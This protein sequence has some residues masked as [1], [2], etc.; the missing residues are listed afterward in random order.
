[1][2]D[3]IRKSEHGKRRKDG[4]RITDE[5]IDL[6]I[7]WGREIH[8]K[9][10]VFYFVGRKEIEKA[11]VEGADIKHCQGVHVIMWRGEIQSVYRNNTPNFRR[12]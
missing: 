2:T 11:K 12:N 8:D 9:R 7:L 4:R 1:M 5:M 6:T 3:E 10:A